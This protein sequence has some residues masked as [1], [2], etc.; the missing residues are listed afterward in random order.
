MSSS[1][2]FSAWRAGSAGE[3]EQWNGKR[4][5]RHLAGGDNSTPVIMTIA[6]RRLPGA[7]VPP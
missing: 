3:H 2:P 4:S 7:P 5:R 1:A 6:T